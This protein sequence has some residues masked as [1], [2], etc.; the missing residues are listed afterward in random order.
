LSNSGQNVCLADWITEESTLQ[1]RTCSVTQTGNRSEQVFSEKRQGKAADIVE[2]ST[3][4]RTLPQRPLRS[5]KSLSHKVPQP[6][7]PPTLAHC[8]PLR[9]I[10][11]TAGR[12]ERVGRVGS[13]HCPPVAVAPRPNN[14][15][16]NSPRRCCQHGGHN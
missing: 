16:L 5:D 13:R 4:P 2:E 12:G 10:A 9:T 1:N 3:H 8:R 6:L 14:S 15:P 11:P 7:G